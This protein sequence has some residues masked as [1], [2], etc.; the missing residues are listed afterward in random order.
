MLMIDAIAIM[1]ESSDLNPEDAVDSQ[2][3]WEQERRGIED[4]TVCDDG[5]RWSDEVDFQHLFGRPSESFYALHLIT[6]EMKQK[7][8]M[9]P[10]YRYKNK[11]I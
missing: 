5:M 1:N 3:E 7:S 11:E 10:Q 6:M 2:L 8:K 4:G 9:Y